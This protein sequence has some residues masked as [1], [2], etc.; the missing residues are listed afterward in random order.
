MPI[1]ALIDADDGAI[2]RK[3]VP[4][5]C[6]ADVK[7]GHPT[8]QKY[9]WRSMAVDLRVELRA[10]YFDVTLG[11]TGAIRMRSG[12]GECKEGDENGVFEITRGQIYSHSIVSGTRKQ[13]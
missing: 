3:I 1:S 12:G 8:V 10:P 9:N 13:L 5:I 2:G 11:A 6:E 7:E 4:L